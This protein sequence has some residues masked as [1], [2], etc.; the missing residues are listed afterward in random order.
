MEAILQGITTPTHQRDPLPI[1]HS[2]H[3]RH[4]SLPLHL[5]HTLISFFLSTPFLNLGFG[6]LSPSNPSLPPKIS[7]PLL[8]ASPLLSSLDQDLISIF[9]PLLKESSFFFFGSPDR[10][11]SPWIEASSFFLLFSSSS[12]LFLS[13]LKSLLFSCNEFSIFLT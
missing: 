5:S 8:K 12:T 3:S 11:S 4:L 6:S 13:I 10:L 1:S 2:P 9:S 7:S